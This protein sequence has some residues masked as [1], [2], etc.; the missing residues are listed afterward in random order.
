ME[1]YYLTDKIVGPPDNS[2]SQLSDHRTISKTTKSGYIVNIQQLTRILGNNYH[3]YI[4]YIDHVY[5]QYIISI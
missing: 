4:Y 5:E 1:N 2:Y 3:N